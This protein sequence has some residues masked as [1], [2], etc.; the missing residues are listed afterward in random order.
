MMQRA[1]DPESFCP[2][3]SATVLFICLV[4]FASG[5]SALIF[6][7]LW[8]HQAGLV[9]GNSVWATSMTLS[10]FM[11]G[12]AL[13]SGLVGRY[14]HRVK[15][16]IRFYALV[17][18]VIATAGVGLTHA[19]PAV[20]G[21]L[22]FLL[23][24]FLDQLLVLN[25]LRFLIAFVLMVAPATAMG[26]TLPLL[27]TTLRAS[28]PRFGRVLGRIFGWNTLGAVAGAL[29]C[30]IVLI[31]H[32]GIKGAAWVAGALNLTVAVA[33]L[34]VA[35]E[36]EKGGVDA[37]T[38]ARSEATPSLSF[39]GR[40]LLLAAFI[41]G[42][43]LLALEV[44]WFRFMTL[45]VMS[46]GLAFAFMLAVIL[47]GIGLG[48]LFAG[49][50][51]GRN[52]ALSR[53]VGVVA[54]A[55]GMCCIANYVA[56]QIGLP[57]ALWI[58]DWN[59]IVKTSFR[60][61]FPTALLSGILFTW[62]GDAANRE[63]GN[64]TRA[65]GLMTLANTTGA[66][67]GAFVGGFVLLPD[68]GMERSLFFLA[69][70]Y[71]AVALA[72]G[73]PA[74]GG[75]RGRRALAWYGGLAAFAIVLGLFPFGLMNNRYI[76]M[77]AQRY[78]GDGAALVGVREGLTETIH[79]MRK[80]FLGAPLYYRLVTSG[81][82]MSATVGSSDRYMKLFSYWPAAVHPNLRS[83]LVI[84][85]G[86]GSTAK[87]LTNTRTFETIDIVDT[88]RDVLDM[89]R[90]VYPNPKD[91]PLHDPR[92]NVHVEDGRQFLLSTSRTFDL[93]TGEPP[94]PRIARTV[95]LY[96]REYFQLIFDR[97]AEHGITTY[98]LPVHQL[99]SSDALAIVR[100]FCDVF[101]DCSLW[102]G[103][104]YDWMLVGT[105]NA[106]GPVSEEQFAKQWQDPVTGPDLRELGVEVPEQ[107]GALFMADAPALKRATADTPPLVD[108]Y[109][110]RLTPAL[111]PLRDDRIRFFRPWMDVRKTRAAFG[112]SAL[113]SRLWPPALRQR[114]LEWFAAQGTINN[115][116]AVSPNA[117]TDVLFGMEPPLGDMNA[118]DELLTRTE[119]RTLPMWLLGSSEQHQRIVDRRVREGRSD[120]AIDYHLG[121][122]AMADRNYDSA[123][124][125]FR[126]VQEQRPTDVQ[127]AL[128]HIY[129]LCLAGRTDAAH[130]VADSF[131][132]RSR[133]VGVRAFWAFV[134]L[135]FHLSKP[136]SELS[137]P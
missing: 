75:N 37:L 63:M 70:G 33:M 131:P 114:S 122:R 132:E 45:F 129:A 64:E 136:G 48:G 52:P 39:A 30:E 20:T 24:P 47:T 107:L 116:L 12:L 3:A 126:T 57:S 93:I 22:V 14:G 40:R 111:S 61:M 99:L 65:T 117:I 2:G 25:T 42:G 58:L 67:V 59:L 84:G 19:F 125:Y 35:R 50:L 102:G 120:A 97:L 15:R 34:R 46:S 6:E 87:S 101:D 96:T 76:R 91:H 27:V 56:F 21:A 60:L 4:S 41:S 127:V 137:A 88:S 9:F 44:V 112:E 68:L 109:P 55:C 104:A 53:F 16:V 28:D 78:T 86:V 123:A 69:A 23:R 51:L 62:L 32:F 135:R 92:V 110:N 7:I 8:F 103:S 98:W 54:L 108:D 119:L 38:T 121:I 128:R 115:G 74:G 26:A 130:A 94:P 134:A 5:A 71:G 77:P 83:V 18:I 43:I 49:F 17:E 80:D 10:S 124:E 29:V 73:A 13:G 11:G 95:S 133:L 89:S 118:L 105:R 81:F 106:V 82:S 90:L 31:T 1:T 72:V 113:V 79:Y 85:Y 36:R 66:M 100:S